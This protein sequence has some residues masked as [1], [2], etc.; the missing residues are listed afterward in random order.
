MGFRASSAMAGPTAGGVVSREFW[1]LPW[2]RGS[3]GG[4]RRSWVEEIRAGYL[5]SN[6]RLALVLVLLWI[7]F[8]LIQ[9]A[10]FNGTAISNVFVS[11]VLVLTLALGETFVM[12]AGW[13]DLSVAGML[14]MSGMVAGKVMSVLY[15]GS[16]SDWALMVGGLACALVVGAVG[17][18]AN[19]FVISKLKVNSLIVTLGS[20][21]VFTGL[22]SVISGGN[23]ITDFPSSVYVVGDGTW[24][25]IPVYV[26]I[27]GVVSVL[28]GWIGRETR[29]GRHIYACGANREALRRAGV[30]VQG[31]TLGVF[32][33]AG[34]LGGL[35]GFLD[36]AHFEA[37]SPVAGSSD[38]LLAVA[39]VVIGGT[40]LEG[41]EGSIAGTVL[42]ALII[43]VLENGFVIINV[44]SYWQEVAI[45]VMTVVAVFMGERRRGR[46]L[47]GGIVRVPVS[48]GGSSS[49][50]DDRGLIGLLVRSVSEK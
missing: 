29:F 4:S 30:S 22:A 12:I 1:R 19:G 35:A 42:G 2:R 49:W 43:S 23:P 7:A 9:P 36:T 31:V 15:S 5:G 46:R 24:G 21:G 11:A 32:G 37:A 38:L 28:Y 25:P 47:Q 14:A 44:S 41:G 26:V 13:I 48:K 50:G 6:L 39:A 3:T 33:I 20:L 34:L 8:G 16:G 45:G 10:F 40:P 27:V 18:I 17:G